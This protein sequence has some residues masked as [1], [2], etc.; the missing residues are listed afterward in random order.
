[1]A[2]PFNWFN[3][4]L[5]VCQNGRKVTNCFLTSAIMNSKYNIQI[6]INSFSEYILSGPLGVVASTHCEIFLQ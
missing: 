5:D 2:L 3:N 4:L 6:A 1:M